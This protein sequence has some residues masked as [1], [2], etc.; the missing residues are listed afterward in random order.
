MGTEKVKHPSG[1][2]GPLH[3][4]RVSQ[5]RQEDSDKTITYEY[6]IDALVPI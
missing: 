6:A 3:D 2:P 4:P 1:D 5:Y